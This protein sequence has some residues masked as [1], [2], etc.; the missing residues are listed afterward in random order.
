M[1][2]QAWSVFR[3]LATVASLG[4]CSIANA[5][6]TNATY[7]S[8]DYNALTCLVNFNAAS[9]TLSVD[10][11]QYLPLGVMTGTF[12]ADSADDPKATKLYTIDNDTGSAWSGYDVNVYMDRAFSISNAFATL[13]ANWSVAVTQPVLNPTP[14][15]FGALE[16]VGHVKYMAGTL[17]PDGGELD[18]QYDVGFGGAS[19]YRF[20]D[21]L[22]PEFAVPE[23][24]VLSLAFVGV[25][26]FCRRS[27]AKRPC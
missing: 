20:A 14:V 2:N 15:Y 4:V 18:F 5:N 21:E 26:L 9:S 22:M 19:S 24:G 3:A 12:Y 27:L 6:L 8:T 7:Y 10:G 25:L 17:V 1:K 16:Y 13:P 11:Y 23:P